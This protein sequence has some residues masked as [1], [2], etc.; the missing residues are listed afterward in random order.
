MFRLISRAETCRWT[1][2]CKKYTLIKSLTLILLT[3]RIWWAPNNA[4][5]WQMGFNS[6]FKGLIELCFWLYIVYIYCLYPLSIIYCLYLLSLHNKLSNT[7]VISC[8]EFIPNC[9]INKGTS[10]FSLYFLFEIYFFML[11]YFPSGCTQKHLRSSSDIFCYFYPTWTETV[12]LSKNIR[13]CNTCNVKF[14]EN[15][16]SFSRVITQIR[17]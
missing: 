6:A 16:F 5:K 17:K 7:R 10:K 15:S 14:N 2:Q 11:S 9:P 8:G 12:T 3:W 4:S 1:K 13:W